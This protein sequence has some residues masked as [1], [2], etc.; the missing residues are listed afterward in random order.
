MLSHSSLFG[1]SWPTFFGLSA[2]DSITPVERVQWSS[3]LNTVLLKPRRSTLQNK[4]LSLTT[5]PPICEVKGIPR[6]AEYLLGTTLS[7]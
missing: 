7:N 6:P 5:V 4:K 2:L 1:V 3:V